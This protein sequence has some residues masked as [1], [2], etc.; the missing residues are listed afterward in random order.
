MKCYAG[1]DVEQIY[2]GLIERYKVSP[3]LLDRLLGSNVERA[4]I[5]GCSL[6]DLL[7]PIPENLIALVK[8]YGVK[9]EV[10]NGRLAVVFPL[11]TPEGKVYKLYRIALE[12]KDKNRLERGAP[13]SKLLFIPSL[14]VFEY[15][16]ITESPTDALVLMLLLFPR[17]L[18]IAEVGKDNTISAIKQHQ[19]RLIELFKGKPIYVW[20][21]PDAE[22]FAENIAKALQTKVK[23]IKID[24]PFEFKDALRIIKQ[25]KDF[26]DVRN[27]IKELLDGAQEIKPFEFKPKTFSELLEERPSSEWIIEG[28]V[29]QEEL[30]LILGRPAVGKTILALNFLKAF[31]EGNT[32][33]G[34]MF[35]KEDRLLYIY[36]EKIA[37]TL[38]T[39]EELEIQEINTLDGRLYNI[40]I[41][42]LGALEY[43]I[44]EEGYKIIVIDPLGFFL[45]LRKQEQLNDYA[46]VSQL[47]TPLKDLISRK[48]IT[49][50]ALHHTRKPIR[51]QIS[52]ADALGSTA[53]STLSDGRILLEKRKGRILA[54]IEGNRIPE[55][56]INFTWEDKT[57][58]LLTPEDNQKEKVAKHILTALKTQKLSRNEIV[59]YIKQIMPKD[60]TEEGY[61]TLVRR[62]LDFL[63]TK[64]LVKKERE[65]K[66]TYYSL[67]TPETPSSA[68]LILQQEKLFQCP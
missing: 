21:E 43:L 13:A 33:L 27:H 32:L 36:Y 50:F 49:I 51:N 39:A 62:A 54:K 59:E 42:N 34:R 16:I 57:P 14:K 30:W 65:G 18:A 9:E 46:Q 8:N 2:E 56:E 19:K 38:E 15:V 52:E 3:E 35:R 66:R 24:Y 5:S 63:L 60:I 22:N 48:K 17:C 20:V 41:K 11:Q 47:L 67:T 44:E 10:Y 25:R 58:T 6:V 1:C 45:N 53:L 26:V 64:K 29:A 68:S 23:A 31:K 12:G 61:K 4:P 7:S 28:W 37:S 40:N 55:Q